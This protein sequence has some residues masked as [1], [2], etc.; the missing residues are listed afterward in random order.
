MYLEVAHKAQRLNRNKNTKCLRVQPNMDHINLM[1]DIKPVKKHART[2]PGTTVRVIFLRA[3]FFTAMKVFLI[4]GLIHGATLYAQVE[5][6]IIVLDQYV[7][8]DFPTV[9]YSII[10]EPSH[11]RVSSIPKIIIAQ[12]FEPRG[13]ALDGENQP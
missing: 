10:A 8:N 12:N 13:P 1:H 6:N 11:I 3:W 9:D 4:A 2:V 5:Q 7:R